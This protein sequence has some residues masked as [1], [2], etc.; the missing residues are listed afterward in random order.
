VAYWLTD[1]V[2]GVIQRVPHSG[3][4]SALC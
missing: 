4:R 2:Y 3:T 1:L